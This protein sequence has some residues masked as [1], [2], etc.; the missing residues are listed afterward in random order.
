ML[1]YATCVYS[2]FS[3]SS[4][5]SSN[6]PFQC[7]SIPQKSYKEVDTFLGNEWPPSEREM[8]LPVHWWIAV[9]ELYS[10]IC[11]YSR[12]LLGS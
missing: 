9:L 7:F 4:G 11:N 12:D 6:N 10:N 5:K 3:S 1:A 2:A 8:K